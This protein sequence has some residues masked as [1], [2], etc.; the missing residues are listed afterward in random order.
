MWARIRVSGT[1]PLPS[2]GHT[3]NNSGPD[4]IF[5]V[6]WGINFGARGEQNF[7]PP[8]DIDY[9]IVLIKLDVYILL[10]KNMMLEK[11]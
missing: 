6:G 7:I 2:Y 1:P 8:S 9:F 3:A 4:I 10:I 5:F 11:I